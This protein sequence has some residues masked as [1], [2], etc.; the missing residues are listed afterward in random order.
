MNI[1]SPATQVHQNI[2]RAEDDVWCQRVV[3]SVVPE[4]ISDTLTKDEEK[5]DSVSKELRTTSD[6]LKVKQVL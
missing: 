2:S 3:S 1:L 4:I 5:A 6:P